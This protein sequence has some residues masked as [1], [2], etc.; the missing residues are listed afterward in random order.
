MCLPWVLDVFMCVALRAT[1]SLD[2]GGKR[3][4]GGWP[5]LNPVPSEFP[6]RLTGRQPG[7][8][9]KQVP[10]MAQRCHNEKPWK[11]A[12]WHRGKSL[13]LKALPPQSMLPHAS[14]KK[15]LLQNCLNIALPNESTVQKMKDLSHTCGFEHT[16]LIRKHFFGFKSTEGECRQKQNKNNPPPAKKRSKLPHTP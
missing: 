5:Q 10:Q 13:Q 7:L 6:P 8:I 9:R 16:A 12:K 2:K 1:I 3:F 4:H 11:T 15:S 14:K